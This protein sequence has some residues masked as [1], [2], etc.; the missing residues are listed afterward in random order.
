MVAARWIPIVDEKVQVVLACAVFIR[1]PG[2]PTPRNALSEWFVIDD[3]KIRIIYTPMFYPPPEL[4]LPNWPPY[5]GNWPLPA[6]NV[7]VPAPTRQ[8]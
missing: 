7:P 5:D 4:A 2:S 1:R 6:G 3:A 8:P